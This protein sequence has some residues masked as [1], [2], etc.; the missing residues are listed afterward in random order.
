MLEKRIHPN[1]IPAWR[2]QY[3]LSGLF[4]FVPPAF[5]YFLHGKEVL[6]VEWSIGTGLLAVIIYALMVTFLPKLR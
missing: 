2:L 6:P 5:L 3:T 4:L 1:A